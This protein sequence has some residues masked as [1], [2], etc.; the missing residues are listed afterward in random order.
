MEAELL[1]N[2][3][4]SFLPIASVILLLLFAVYCLFSAVL[5]YHWKEYATNQL[6][7]KR[8][9]RIY[10]ISTGLLFFSALLS[11]GFLYFN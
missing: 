6:V 9:L 5:I 7:M 8:T 4:F 10:F 2:L 1:T 11:L 3:T